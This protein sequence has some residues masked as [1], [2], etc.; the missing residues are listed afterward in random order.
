M[1]IVMGLPTMGS[2]VCG[3]RLILSKDI[4]TPNSNLKFNNLRR[5]FS[6]GDGQPANIPFKSKIRNKNTKLIMGR[7]KLHG[8]S[9][10]GGLS[11]A[12][13][14]RKI[15]HFENIIHNTNGMEENFVMSNNTKPKKPRLS[16][17][18]ELITRVSTGLEK[19]VSPI[20]ANQQETINT[21]MS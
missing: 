12:P 9:K 7:S 6:E 5:M 11:P 8:S 21:G 18:S 10:L 17:L 14:K 13:V 15:E 2:D 19:K 16:E 3:V 20:K 1:I 4:H